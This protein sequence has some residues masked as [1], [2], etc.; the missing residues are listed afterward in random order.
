MA[1]AAVLGLYVAVSMI[2]CAIA[3]KT[4]I[5]QRVMEYVL[6]KLTIK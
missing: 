5:G 3:S 1:T 4:K 2:V 6:D